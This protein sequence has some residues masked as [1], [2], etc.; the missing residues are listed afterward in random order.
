MNEITWKE[1]KVIEMKRHEWNNEM[2]W[3]ELGWMNWHEGIE[4]NELKWMNCHERIDMNEFTWM[5]WSEWL[6]MNHL[7]SMNWNW[8]M[9]TNELRKM[10]RDPQ[11]F[12]YDF[13]R[14]TTCWLFCWHEIELSLQSRAPFADLIFQKCSKTLMSV[15]QFFC[16]I[17]LSLQSHLLS[18]SSSKSGPRPS[19]FYDFSVKSSS[20][21]SLV[22]ILS[23]SS[24]KSGLP[25]SFLRSLC[26]IELSLQSRAHF[27][28]LI[29][30]K[31]SETL[32]SVLRFFCE[33]ELS[34]Q[35]RTLFVDLIFQKRSARQF[36]F[37]VFMWNRALVAVSWT[38]C[39]PLSLIEARNR[40]NTNPP[41][42]TTDCHF[43]RKK[44]RVLH[45][46]VFS[47]VNSRVLDRS[48]FPTTW[49][50]CSWHDDW[51]DDVVAVIVRQLA[52]TIVRNS[53][54]S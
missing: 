40:G 7:K 48:H 19:V 32:M 39:R 1:R 44:R 12:S 47:S 54:V 9:E 50:W 26:E 51:D 49:W 24:S 6:E 5:N 37:A 16:E 36:F 43:T 35:S 28:D 20:P 38:F 30:Q 18:T 34:L 2:T 52:M 4:M 53:E 8:W 33:I 17:E 42:A 23:T 41:A 15:L 29:F 11:L 21:C 45:P 31:C 27:A 25:V 3:N 10:L 14:S 22:H 13:M 46:K